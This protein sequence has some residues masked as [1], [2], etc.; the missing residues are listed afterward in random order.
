MNDT[1]E[2]T[3]VEE[4]IVSS[5]LR[6]STGQFS[7]ATTRSTKRTIGDPLPLKDLESCIVDG[8]VGRMNT[9]RSSLLRKALHPVTSLSSAGKREDLPSQEVLQ[10]N[11]NAEEKSESGDKGEGEVSRPP[12]S[13]PPPPTVLDEDNRSSESESGS[14]SSS[15]SDSDPRENG[16]VDEMSDEVGE[17]SQKSK[18]KLAGG[19]PRGEMRTLLQFSSSNL[20][21]SLYLCVCAYLT[22]VFLHFIG[23]QKAPKSLHKYKRRRR[24]GECTSCLIAEDCGNCVFCLDKPKFGGPNIKK[25]ACMCVV[26]LCM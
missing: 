10:R 9:R 2:K 5:K 23:S 19:A 26:L 7:K 15:D 12:L 11:D 1:Q 6:L 17:Q 8:S 16:S 21:L 3:A 24:C 13:P 18:L 4:D 14:G 25:Q 22:N 20:S